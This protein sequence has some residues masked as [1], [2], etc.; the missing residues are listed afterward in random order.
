[1]TQKDEKKKKSRQVGNTQCI[2]WE[3]INKHD[4]IE[5]KLYIYTPLTTNS[6]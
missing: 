3:S 6:L 5:T 2:S 1:M 4:I